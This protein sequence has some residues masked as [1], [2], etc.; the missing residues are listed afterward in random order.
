MNKKL[1][2]FIVTQNCYVKRDYENYVQQN[3]NKHKNN[4][5]KSW[6]YLVKLL[7]H[8][9]LLNK[10]N[11]L[12]GSPAKNYSK[13][14]LKY[15]EMTITQ[16]KDIKEIIEILSKY[17]VISFDVFDT[18]IFRAIEDPKDLFWLVG[19][20]FKITNYKQIR[21]D[22]EKE[23][24]KNVIN[25]EAD[26]DKI[27]D[28][29]SKRFGIDKQKAIEYEFE[30]E[31]KMCFSNPYMK[32]IYDELIKRGKCVVATSNMY[33]NEKYLKILLDR[34]GY[35]NL[36][37]IFVSCDYKCNKRNGELQK[38]V[39]NCLGDS[40]S[41]I[42]VGDNYEADI[43]G[44]RKIGWQ[45]IYYKNVNEIG[46]NY[47]RRGMSVLNGSILAGLTNA[48]F[49]N[50]LTQINPYFECGYAYAGILVYGYCEW[51]NQLARI[52]NIDKFIFLARD[53]DI[54]Y[55]MYKEYFNNIDS[56][57]VLAS[58]TATVHLSLNRHLEQFLDWHVKRRV[59]ENL[60]I[61]DLFT[62]LDLCF[63]DKHLSEIGLECNAP[64]NAQNYD[65][66]KE[67]IY[68]HKQE[69]LDYFDDEKEAARKYFTPLLDGCKNVCVIDLGWKGS[70]A[71]SLN[72]FWNEECNL[73]VN[74]HTA[75]IAS[76]G[77]Q[78]V[79]TLISTKKFHSYIFS[80]QNNEGWMNE[81]NK[82]G[83]IWRLVYEMLFTSTERSLLKYSLDSNGNFEPIYLRKEKRDLRIINDIQKG[84]SEFC[85]DYNKIISD[86]DCN[87]Q[88]SPLEAYKPLNQ[89]LYNK[90]F[91]YELFK[92]FEVCFLAGNVS[93]EKGEIFGK[94]LNG[95][96]N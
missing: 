85:K 28:I 18:L 71:S 7:V 41:Y 77:H 46:K 42:H 44:S 38:K 83:N 53:M 6:S 43:E 78:Y 45:A 59:H 47:R 19:N 86:L 49:H 92:D 16:R 96:N 54:V 27:Y 57:Y 2:D 32:K 5:M 39:Q 80:S 66:I 94:V 29:I 21:A 51:L 65:E 10:T 35:G 36:S 3:I 23:A 84:I 40:L 56:E 73:N 82:N 93:E 88:I 89:L 30:L 64:F 95:K 74:V 68:N 76:E 15:P 11:P 63:L 87:I 91:C 69:L 52:H 25:G 37:K 60:T 17:D 58:R 4:R 61:Q 24:R 8:Y 75:V 31:T 33:L 22:I 50:G 62:E 81:H 34:C 9:R 67:L 20:R 79:D 1:Y 72:Y 55:K 70:I 48:K 12:K 90:D 26:I 14:Y 13:P